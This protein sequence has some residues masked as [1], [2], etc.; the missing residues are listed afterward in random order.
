MSHDL[1]PAVEVTEYDL[2]SMLWA[3]LVYSEQA[4]QAGAHTGKHNAFALLPFNPRDLDRSIHGGY[5]GQLLDDYDIEP[6]LTPNMEPF[7]EMSGELFQEGFSDI[8]DCFYDNKGLLDTIGEKLDS[9][10]N[11]VI[12]TNHGEIYDIAIIQAALR[13]ALAR[14]AVDNERPLLTADRFNLIVNRM[15]SQLGVP[16]KENPDSVPAP[17]LSILQLVGETYL[18][19]P[20]TENSKKAQ[21]PPELDRKCNDLMLESLG[22]KMSTGG[23]ILAFAPSGSTDESILD[24]FGKIFKV[25]KPVN[26]GTYR[27]MQQDKT[28]ILAVGV[29]LNQDSGPVCSVSDLT[30]CQ[31]DDE[32]DEL[33]DSIAERHAGLTK[34]KTVYARK[35]ADIDAWRKEHKETVHDV[36]EDPEKRHKVYLTASAL[37]G[38]AALLGYLIGRR[39]AKK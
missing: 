8:I 10:E 34:I 21:I 5:P 37:A 13:V 32:C 9:D 29:A 20:R 31:T 24:K 36:T 22:N 1:E 15:I 12:I 18:S 28:W 27:L 6:N 26:A 14:H 38:S 23:Q 39:S 25:I 16:D 35:Q 3:K 11:I 19:F 30:K 2:K 4:Q 7:I 33:L 17:A